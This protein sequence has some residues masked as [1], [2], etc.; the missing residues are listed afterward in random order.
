MLDFS[1][2][3]LSTGSLH[4]LVMLVFYVVAG[5]YTIF[6][7]I[8]YYHWHTY[9]SDTKVSVYTLTAYFGTTLPLLLV[10]FILTR[11]I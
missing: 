11:L 10:M 9:S 1:Q 4:T 8:L 7:G 2:F 5:I 6:S 3:T